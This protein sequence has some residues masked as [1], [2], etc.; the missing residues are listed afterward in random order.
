[1]LFVHQLELI[2]LGKTSIG[3]AV[4]DYIRAFTQRSRWSEEN[5]LTAGEIGK[6]ERRLKEEWGVLFADME[7]DLG[8]EATEAE[9][10]AAAKR[11]YRWAQLEARLHIRPNC[12]ESFV[13]RGSFHILANNS[14]IGWHID[15]M[16]RLMA[17][18]EPAEA[19]HT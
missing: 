15:Y 14:E 4:R 11:I 5:L 18:L 2:E 16:A 8:S 10:I 19:T 9:K 3:N 1:M 7:D 13:F 17:I 6:Y 12:D